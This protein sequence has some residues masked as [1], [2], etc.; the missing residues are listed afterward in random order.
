MEIKYS[1]L[2]KTPYASTFENWPVRPMRPV[3]TVRGLYTPV[4]RL[5]VGATGATG[6]CVFTLLIAV[7][8]Y[9]SR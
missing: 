8:R 3:R 9:M 5:I 2:Q 7:Y 1:L 6:N 4:L